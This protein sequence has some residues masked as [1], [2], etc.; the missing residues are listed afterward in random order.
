M[1]AIDFDLPQPPGRP[2]PWGTVASLGLH[3]ALAL[4]LIVLSPLRQ[5]VVPPPEPVAVEIVTPS[6][7]AALQPRPSAPATPAPVAQPEV[8]P[9]IATPPP[10]SAD[11][12]PPGAALQPDLPQNKTHTA[13]KFYSASILREPKMARIRQTFGT[14]A[15]SEKLMQLC[16]I[17]GLE[18]IRLAE[19]D[20]APDTL[21]SYAMADPMASGLTLTAMGGAFRSRRKWY[22]VSL[23][24]TVA[25]DYRGVTA[26]E[27]SLGEPIPEDQWEEHNL[28][29]ADED[30]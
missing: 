18:Q 12:L 29:A 23:K 11:R 28:N 3:A 22:G 10:A 6:Q 15:D 21:V 5:L 1:T 26:F 13:T 14:L 2:V 16:N 9:E 30:E 20:Y 27:F 8:A 25:P 19:P 17:E 7:F 4:A 24:C